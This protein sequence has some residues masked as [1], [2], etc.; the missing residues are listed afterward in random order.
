M[1]VVGLVNYLF[2]FS[3]ASTKTALYDLVLKGW[4]TRII[5]PAAGDIRRIFVGV[6]ILEVNS[7]ILLGYYLLISAVPI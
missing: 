1:T 2:P 5:L 7:R 3:Q 4:T 6:L